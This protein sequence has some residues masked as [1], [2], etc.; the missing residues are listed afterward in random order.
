[1]AYE[2]NGSSPSQLIDVKA[3]LGLTS[4][5]TVQPV[6]ID[7]DD[8]SDCDDVLDH[9]I[10]MELALRNEC[11]ILAV[12]IAS[13]NDY[14]APA[15]RA[16]FD[17]GGFTSVPI[18]A[19]KGSSIGGGTFSYYTQQ[20]AA[21]FRP[22]G[23]TRTSYP[24]AVTVLRQALVSS[25]GGVKIIVNGT[26]TNIAALLA[27]SGDGI[28]SLNGVALVA[29]KVNSIHVMGGNF[30]SPTSVENNIAFDVAA[31]NTVATTSPVP[32]YWSG[33]EIGELALT[34]ISPKSGNLLRDPFYYAWRLSAALLSGGRRPSWGAL[35]ILEAVRGTN[36][37]MLSYSAPGD[38]TFSA[39]S[40]Y[41]N[42]TA[43]ASGKSRYAILGSS[44]GL[45]SSAQ[46][47]VSNF[48]RRLADESSP[49][50]TLWS[51]TNSGI[52]ADNRPDYRGGLTGDTYQEGVATGVHA[53]R[54]TWLVEANAIYRVSFDAESINW[55]NVQ[56]VLDNGNNGTFGANAYAN[57]DIANGV[58]TALGS[59]VSNFAV[60]TL[61]GRIRRYSFDVTC[62]AD[63]TGDLSYG[64]ISTGSAARN[65]SW[66]ATGKSS[67]ISRATVRQIN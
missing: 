27:S 41:T 8:D 55:P 36:G 48:A 45:Q 66:T 24:D 7:T 53:I 13:N 50:A 15:A 40:P 65:E 56:I 46:A 23:E 12:T 2:I 62:L 58:S 60:E 52:Q 1:M 33:Y 57:I 34:S 11:Q 38:V 30:A 31:A 64:H 43:N 5:L 4:P 67:G 54:H 22:S 47:L 49:F 51:Q 21:R 39:T 32:V 44:I 25:A 10:A 29:A 17:A 9:Q 18:G 26:C 61:S 59:A 28:S 37:G 63:G 35:E 19:Y 16:F 20:V 6:I 14:A 3:A 42:Y